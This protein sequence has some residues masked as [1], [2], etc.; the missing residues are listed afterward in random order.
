[1]NGRTPPPIRFKNFMTKKNWLT[2]IVLLGLAGVYAFC[3]TDWFK[4]KII[5][6]TSINARTTRGNRAN[7]DSTTI[8]IIFKLGRPY[9]LTELKVVDL[10]EWQT[11]ENCRPLWHLIADTNSAPIERPFYYGQRL[12]GLK[13]EVPGARAQPLQAGVT[14]RLFVTD[15]KAKGQHDFE[16]KATD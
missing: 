7:T 2:M 12:R 4:P 6:I 14:Y 16:V 5:H 15:G 11:N 10:G 8:P 13:P 9:K 3:F 1:M